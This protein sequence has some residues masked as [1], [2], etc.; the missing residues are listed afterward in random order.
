MIS[1]TGSYIILIRLSVGLIF[2]SEGI[3][4]FLFS[5]ELGA[6]RFLKIGIPYSTFVAPV[7]GVT[8]IL[9]G[10]LILIGYKTSK[11]AVP[12]LFI[13]LTAIAFTKIIT[14]PEKGFWS[15]AHEAR[16]D[17]AMLLS[18]IFLLL[19]GSGKYSLDEYLENRKQSN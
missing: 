12:L 10:L 7:I 16:T 9:S 14:L 4:K 11:A 8:E 5:P 17:F 2:L 19:C 1:K 18:S 15:V 6:G 13:M 3:Q